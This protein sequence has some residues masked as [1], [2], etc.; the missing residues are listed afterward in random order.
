MFDV[1][2]IRKDF[3]MLNNKKVNNQELI[4]LDSAATTFK[5]NVV[6]DKVVDYYHNLSTNAHRGDYDLS[7]Q[8]SKEFDNVRE[9]IAKFINCKAEEV[10][11]TSGASMSLNL[12]AYGFGRKILKKGDIILTTEAE[13]ASSILPWFKTAE[14]CGAIVQY[15]PLDAEGRITIDNFKS[16]LN[17]KVKIV[18]FANVTNVLGFIAPVK[19]LIELAHNNKAYVIV[20]G[21]Q[22]VPHLPTDVQRDD[23][24]FL[25]FSAHKLCGPTGVGVLYGKY[26]L[27]E[28]TDPFM[29]GGGANARFDTCGNILLKQPPF[30]FE[31]GTP[32]IEGVLGMGK[33]IE[34][35]NNIGIENIHKYESELRAYL[36]SKLEVLDNIVIYNKH[37]DAGIITF[38]IDGIFAQDAAGY[39]NQHGICLRAGNHCAKILMNILGTNETLRASFY[40]YNT[41]AEIDKFV[42]VL[43]EISLEKCIEGWL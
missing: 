30:K 5:P 43:S 27:L 36:V 31:A 29:M 32:A 13:H 28:M 41:K 17:D 11:F 42:E 15:I 21:A 38:N 19:E 22:G 10:V 16:V 9:T 20:D 39:L 23:I 8:V 35:I 1:K 12:V 14:E 24:D 26:E 34:Y 37:A 40:F 3:P 4:Y 18:S 2:T 25:A 6:I 33:A 7:F